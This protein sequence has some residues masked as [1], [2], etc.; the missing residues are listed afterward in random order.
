ML[1]GVNNRPVF[2]GTVKWWSLPGMV[3]LGG[4]LAFAPV[5]VAL[6]GCATG[7]SCANQLDLLLEAERAADKGAVL[8][9]AENGGLKI[10]IGDENFTGQLPP[11][12]PDLLN[13]VD[14]QVKYDGLDISRQLNV[15]IIPERHSISA[16]QP[17]AF[18]ASWNY[19][20]F[21]TRAEV[22]IYRK[23]DKAT[24]GAV[25]IPL[26]T[27]PVDDSGHAYWLPP[28]DYSDDNE[29]V[30]TL[31]VHD[32]GGRFDETFPLALRLQGGDDRFESKGKVLAPGEGEDRTAISNIPLN[33]GKVTVYGRNVPEGYQVDVLGRS[34]PVD[35]QGSFVAATILQSGNH[36]VDVSVHKPGEGRGL[37]IEREISIPA[38]DWFYLGIADVTLG[39]RF[40]GDS[41]LLTPAAPGEYDSVYRKGRLAFYLKG[42]VKGRYLITAAM[43]TKEQDLGLLFTNL[44]AKDP[45]QLLRRLDPDDYYAVYGDD[46]TTVEDAPTS[47]K[48][49]VRI[50]DGKSRVMWGNFRTSFN[51][52]E[53]VRF[54]RGLYGA[55]AELRSSATTSLGE[56]AGTVSA[57]AAQPGTLP[58]RDEFRGTGGSVYFLRRQD[59]TIGSEQLFIEER[60]AVTGLV[61]VRKSLRSG[62]DYEMDYIQGIVILADPLASTV[63][64]SGAITSPTLSGDENHLVVNYE[65]TPAAGNV[66]GYSYGGRAQVWLNDHVRLGATGISE[67]T[68]PADQLLFGADLVLRH[69]EKTYFEFEWARSNGNGFGTVTSTDGGF[70]FDTTGAFVASS[71]NADAWRAKA[72]LD[73]SDISHGALTGSV[74]VHFQN[75]DKGYNA[76]GKSLTY[77][78]RIWGAFAEIGTDETTKVS[79]RYDETSRGDGSRREEGSAEIHHR[80]NDRWSVTLGANHSLVAGSTGSDGNGSRTDTGVRI[81]HK[82]SDTLDTWA[83]GQVTAA[84]SGSRDRNDRIGFGAEKDFTDKI[85]GSAELSYGSTGIGVLASLAYSPTASDRYHIGYRM[86]PDTTAGGLDAYNP[87]SSDY[88]AVV[89]GATRK[90]SDS[91]SMRSEENYDLIGSQRSLTHTYGLTYT[92]EPEWKISAGVEAGEIRDAKN[93]DFNRIAASGAVGYKGDGRSTSLRLEA[94]FENG[95]SA[96]ARDRN[97][98]LVTAK[99]GLDYS[100]DWRFLTSLDAAISQSGQDTILDG[101]YIEGSIGFA[102]RPVDNDRLNALFKYTYLHDLPGAQQVNALNVDNGPR[103]RSHIVSADFDYALNE[104]LSVGG[105][106]G[107]RIGDVSYDRSSDDFYR[108]TAHLGIVRADFHVVKEWDILVEGRALMLSE[109]QQ[110]NFGALAGVYRHIGDNMK[111][112]VGYNF[113]RFSDD[114]S[115]LVMDDQGVFVNVI[116]K[117]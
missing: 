8:P 83:I 61:V 33:G 63:S 105:K 97:T 101:D 39:K 67:N 71:G 84:R 77:S 48:F 65:Y 107:L 4:L 78:E 96:D 95:L 40:G 108:S 25:A 31:R 72:V 106:Y 109:Q 55:S 114:L 68:G 15:S 47:G 90:L 103:Q 92:P 44:D 1:A 36:R 12:S 38:S 79:L 7:K 115:D 89:F 50:E 53:L 60:D 81:D 91:L 13:Q 46:S 70:I 111:L 94:R 100:Q 74:G 6:A 18:R 102:Y 9:V 73:L 112:G 20:E 22:R 11:G 5:P 16:N 56:T 113:G 45:R 57:F 30:Y 32:A 64:S 27:I 80:I 29:L 85:T 23:L 37:E 2:G 75:G 17:V 58:Q 35:P 21:I 117:F 116:G 93:G 62:T 49:Y 42:K 51:G 52:V 104:R 24:P 43:D 86:T 69:S 26:E 41:K 3:I 66:E 76:P 54:D 98:Y 28:A 59:V 99:S 34:V 87:F 14:I 110:V 10:S 19:G 82:L 88:G